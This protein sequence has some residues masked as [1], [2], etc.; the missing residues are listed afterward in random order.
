[1]MKKKQPERYF[2]REDFT[3]DLEDMADA[4][5]TRKYSENAKNVIRQ[6][7]DE[8][9]QELT[10]KEAQIDAVFG[11]TAYDEGTMKLRLAL[12]R[13]FLQTDR[14]L[15]PEMVELLIDG[16]TE[17]IKEGKPWGRPNK[18]PPLDPVLLLAVQAISKKF[19]GCKPDIAACLGISADGVDYQIK[20]A[21]KLNIPQVLHLFEDNMPSNQVDALELLDPETRDNFIRKYGSIVK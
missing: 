21:K 3:L 18:K 14:K 1:M 15:L 2:S 5:T 16:I 6:Y 7:K 4:M 11:G 8:P 20:Q 9:P 13:Y 12:T 19:R 17:H 10:P